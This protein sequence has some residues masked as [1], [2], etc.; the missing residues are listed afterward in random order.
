M[1]LGSLGVCEGCFSTILDCKKV[2]MVEFTKRSGYLH[3]RVDGHEQKVSSVYK[4]YHEQHGEVPKDLLRRFSV[5]KKCRN[6]FDCLVN[7]M[8]FI[9]DL[10]PTLKVQSDSIRAK[11]CT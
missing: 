11:V 7:E 8:L 3:T 10:K 4:H 1:A 9:R 5:L 2:L 6:K